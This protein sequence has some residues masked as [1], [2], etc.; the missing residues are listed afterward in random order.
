[1]SSRKVC[2]PIL[3]LALF[4]GTLSSLQAQPPRIQGHRSN[5]GTLIQRELSSRTLFQSMMDFLR[6][7]VAPDSGSPGQQPGNGT[8]PGPSETEREGAGLCPNGRPRG[9]H[10][11]NGNH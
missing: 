7:I 3:V 9:L 11:G 6:L 1:M 4:L 5:T 8:G 2:T 10:P